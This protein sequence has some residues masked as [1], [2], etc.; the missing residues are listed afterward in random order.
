MKAVIAITSVVMLTA[1]EPTPGAG[2]LRIKLFRECM[3][4]A[5][6]TSHP[7]HY[8]DNA[9]VV[10]ACSNQALYMSNHAMRT[11]YRLQEKPHDG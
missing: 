10:S 2:E 11:G 8:N 7:G 1:C 9:E 3:E 4:L 6:S 5:S